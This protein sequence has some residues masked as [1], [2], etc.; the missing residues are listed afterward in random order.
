VIRTDLIGK[1]MLC[2]LLV[3]GCGSGD[4]ETNGSSTSSSAPA[5]SRSATEQEAVEVA[6][7]YV[8]AVVARDFDSACA[9]RTEK[10]QRELARLGGSCERALQAALGD[11]AVELFDGVR[12]GDVRIEGDRAGVDI[13][14]PQQSKPV[15]TLVAVRD[16]GRWRLEDV[17]DSAAP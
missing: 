10:E 14:Q 12:A 9:T 8:R 11:K 7:R 1:L 6:L 3:V 16:H 5:N 2:A 17:P 13:L 4:K 15:A